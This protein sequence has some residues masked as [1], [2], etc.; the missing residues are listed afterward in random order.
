VNPSSFGF[1]E[2]LGNLSFSKTLAVDTA[3]ASY[4][5]ETSLIQVILTQPP[6]HT[7]SF[8]HGLGSIP[9]SLF[10]HM[11]TPSS[12]LGHSIGQKSSNQVIHTTMDPQAT[13]P[14]YR[15]SQISTPYIGGQ[16]SMGGQPSSWGKPLAAWKLFIGGAPT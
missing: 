2:R 4:L 8:S 5:P 10:P 15:P 16:Y 14:P 6:T 1:P 3:G 11:H 12:L 13:Q 9:A 7:S